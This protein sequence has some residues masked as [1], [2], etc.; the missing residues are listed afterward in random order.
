MSDSCQNYVSL[1]DLPLFRDIKEV[2]VMEKQQNK[3]GRPG[4]GPKMA[5]KSKSGYNESS[6]GHHYI[7]PLSAYNA[8]EE[9]PYFPSG[10][11]DQRFA[12]D[13]LTMRTDQAQ[14]RLNSVRTL[15][16]DCI[17]PIGVKET[18]KQLQERLKNQENSAKAREPGDMPALSAMQ[19]N[20]AE[21]IVGFHE[22]G[23]E[24]AAHIDTSIGGQLHAQPEEEDED[25]SYD[26]DA[27]FA[28]VEEEGDD[29]AGGE[30]RG[31]AMSFRANNPLSNRGTERDVTIQ[32]FVE[33]SHVERRPYDS[34]DE[35]E[36]SQL[37]LDP[38]QGESR[39]FMEV[40]W[41]EVS[42]TVES[43]GSRRISSLNSVTG[44]VLG[45]RRDLGREI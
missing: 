13:E 23:D 38:D 30:L 41:V 44:H 14:Q 37:N 24:A 4:D 1:G 34:Q 15:G 7:P 35:Y 45:N 20:G 31:V 22:L 26:Y 5:D 27:E 25:L 29:E 12:F 42:D 10:A 8:I 17:R 21:A 6:P 9:T 32:Q 36:T 43:V 33:T 16:W 28:R 40:P 2:L 39:E 19:E 11:K 18:M 3:T